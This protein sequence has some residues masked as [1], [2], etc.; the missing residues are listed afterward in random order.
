MPD[1]KCIKC[2]T[3]QSRGGRWL[4]GPGGLQ[5]LCNAC[6]IAWFREKK[7]EAKE[8]A[9]VEKNDEVSSSSYPPARWLGNGGG[10]SPG[11]GGGDLTMTALWALRANLQDGI[12]AVN[13]AMDSSGGRGRIPAIVLVIVVVIITVQGD[14]PLSLL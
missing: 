11:A 6:G 12:I 7:G 4:T 3:T 14:L 10:N 2:C 1:H 13:T 8:E 9:K 5:T